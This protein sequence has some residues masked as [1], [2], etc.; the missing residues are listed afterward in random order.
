M[1]LVIDDNDQ[2]RA[3]IRKMLEV[4]G[5]EV[6]EAAD[7]DE[8]LT[9]FDELRPALVICDLMMPRKDGFDTVRDMLKLVPDAK[10]VAVSGALFGFADHE[11]MVENLGLAAVLEKPFPAGA[12]AGLSKGLLACEVDPPNR[13]EI[14]NS[15]ASRYFPG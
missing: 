6:R 4:S 11:Q 8:G 13:L 1:I 9:L 7:G 14:R 3:M 15:G 12:T 2:Q 10:I 5:Y